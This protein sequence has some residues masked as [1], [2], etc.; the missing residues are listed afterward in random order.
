MTSKNL[1]L[2]ENSNTELKSFGLKRLSARKSIPATPS[3][4]QILKNR[5][6]HQLGQ[7]H[8]HASSVMHVGSQNLDA[9]GHETQTATP[10]AAKHRHPIYLSHN[11]SGVSHRNTTPSQAKKAYQ[12]MNGQ[13]KPLLQTN[14][15][16]ASSP[17]RI[18]AYFESGTNGPGII[19]FDSMAGTSY[20]TY[21]IASRPGTMNEFLQYLQERAP[22]YAARLKQAGPANTGGKTGRMPAVWQQIA[23]EDP[24]G[25]ERLQR[26]FIE[27]THYLP[28]CQAITERTGLRVEDQ[29]IPVQEAIFSTAVQHGPQGAA[30]IVE[31]A[32]KNRKTASSQAIVQTIYT[33]RMKRFRSSPLE[34]RRA[35]ASRLAQERDMIMAALR[36]GHYLAD[37]KGLFE[38][39]V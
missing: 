5:Q 31:R 34:I 23:A 39:P 27:Q 4:A 32:L 21:Q 2:H 1:I 29:P 17:G 3:F 33:E 11:Y 35:V 8:N 37:R 30:N 14:I 7:R 22:A 28:A 26:D 19:G 18:S 12:A 10:L 15:L 25:F 20:G 6:A 13:G 24:A 16:T 36:Q 38:T 9:N